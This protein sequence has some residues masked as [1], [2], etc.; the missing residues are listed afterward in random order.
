MIETR[1]E[2]KRKGSEGGGLSRKNRR[3]SFL[4]SYPYLL[5]LPVILLILGVIAGMLSARGGVP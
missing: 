3:R 5:A 2:R 1:K 4:S